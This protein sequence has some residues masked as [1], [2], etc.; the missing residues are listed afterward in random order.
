MTHHSARVCTDGP[1]RHAR[2]EVNLHGQVV[3]RRRQ[4]HLCVEA[5][6]ARDPSH[7]RRERAEARACARTYYVYGCVSRGPGARR[8]D[9]AA[10]S[11]SRMLVT[12]ENTVSIDR[13]VLATSNWHS[14][15]SLVLL[16]SP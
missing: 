15:V 16:V 8:V 7:G 12:T 9:G 10:S 4:L 14:G 13:A 5:L 3:V 11:G 1:E 6:T 2:G